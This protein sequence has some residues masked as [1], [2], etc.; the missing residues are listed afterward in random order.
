MH[1]IGKPRRLGYS[2]LSNKADSFCSREIAIVEALDVRRLSL[3]V[4]TIEEYF[5]G[6]VLSYSLQHLQE[7]SFCLF[8]RELP[9]YLYL[10]KS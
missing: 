2:V 10:E 6:L 1:N 9:A 3:Q 7:G 4:P 5:L 8:Q